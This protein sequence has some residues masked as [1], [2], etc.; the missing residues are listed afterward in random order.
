[1]SGSLKASLSSD[2]NFA[3]PDKERNTVKRKIALMGYPCV[4]KSSITMRFV[5]GHFPDAYDTTI[6]DLHSKTHRFNGKEYILQITDTAG[7]QE[8]SIF[9]RSC[10]V[11]IDG[12]VL[13]YAIDDER[14]FDIVQSIRDKIVESVGDDKIP[15]LLV[16]NKTDLQYA[17]RVIQKDRGEKL[18]A[19]WNAGFMEISAKDCDKVSEI[20][21][22]ILYRIEVARGNLVPNNK[23]KCTIS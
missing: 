18:A 21:D 1:M 13:V 14:S 5:Q 6:E 7:Q 10:S 19:S 2:G 8:Y 9:P 23:G 17:S 3:Q 15:C 11:G 4:G 20:F 22:K 16:G 12:F